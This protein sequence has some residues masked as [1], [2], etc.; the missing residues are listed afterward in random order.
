MKFDV[1]LIM[2]VILTKFTRLS[3]RVADDDD[4]QHS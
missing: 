3:L 4:R 2:K 1:A